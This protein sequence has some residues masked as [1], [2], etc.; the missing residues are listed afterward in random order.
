MPDDGVITERQQV[1]FEAGPIDIDLRRGM[2][3][4]QAGG[5]GVKQSHVTDELTN[6]VFWGKYVEVMSR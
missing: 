6:R 1:A 2:H 5:M 4:E 3:R